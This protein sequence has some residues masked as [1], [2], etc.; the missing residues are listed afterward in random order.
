MDTAI[1]AC[2]PKKAKHDSLANN[3]ISEIEFGL[4]GCKKDD[5]FSGIDF[6]EIS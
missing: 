2:H 6:E 3:S 1:I 5:E 4:V